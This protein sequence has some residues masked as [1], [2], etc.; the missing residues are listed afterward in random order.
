[1]TGGT[2]FV[3]SH[4]THTFAKEGHK[5]SILTRSDRQDRALPEGCRFVRGDPTESGAWQEDVKGHD[6]AVNLAGAGIFQRWTAS[7][8]RTIS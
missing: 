7:T 2:G 6:V 4:L 5:V 8:K 1:M 3:G